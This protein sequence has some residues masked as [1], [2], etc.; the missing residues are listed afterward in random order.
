[1]KYFLSIIEIYNKI[2]LSKL[3]S[4]LTQKNIESDTIESQVNFEKKE[5]LVEKINEKFKL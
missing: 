4:I 3:K 2:L 5:P 1:M